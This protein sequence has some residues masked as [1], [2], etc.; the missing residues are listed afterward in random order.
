[1]I[2]YQ[3]RS[4]ARNTAAERGKTKLNK[5]NLQIKSLPTEK[6]CARIMRAASVR[7]GRPAGTFRAFVFQRDL[8][9]NLFQNKIGSFRSS[10]N[11]QPLMR[12]PDLFK[13]KIDSFRNYEETAVSK[14]L[15]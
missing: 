12:L 8:K 2:P 15:F 10:E 7:L 13:N 1:L 4:A 14:Y 3:I 9:T 11:T 5:N 6:L